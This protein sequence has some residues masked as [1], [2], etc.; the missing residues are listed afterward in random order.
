MEEAKIPGEVDRTHY[1]IGKSAAQNKANL[2]SG[3]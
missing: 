3:Y 1:D 2:A